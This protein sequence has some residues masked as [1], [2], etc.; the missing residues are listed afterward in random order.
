MTVQQG[1]AVPRQAGVAATAD[2]LR[3]VRV[4]RPGATARAAQTEW[5]GLTPFVHH[6][7]KS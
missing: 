6:P 1:A 3:E 2:V 7:G 4:E 5:D